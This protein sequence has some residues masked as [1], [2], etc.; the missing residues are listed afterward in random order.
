MTNIKKR[1]GTK[2]ISE[3]NG[4]TA[5]ELLITLF[6]A[7]MFLASGFQLYSVVMKSGGETRVQA[8]ASNIMYEYL[9]RYKN[10]TSDLCTAQTP[11]T[12]Q[13]V[14][15]TG[16]ASSTVTVVITCPYG[17]T[18]PIS[19]VAVSVKYGNPQQTVSEATFIKP[20]SIVND[21]L[22]MNLDAGSIKSFKG[23]RSVINWDSWTVGTGAVT[24]YALNGDG[25]SR[26]IDTNPWGNADVVWDTSNQDSAND[27]D[28]GWDGSSFSIDK[29]KMYRFSTWVRRK[30]IGIKGA[31]FLGT[32]G[33]GASVLNRSDGAANSNPYFSATEWWGGE[34]QWYLVVGYVWPAGSGTGAVM[35][36]SGIFMTNGVKVTSNADFVW[37]PTTT[38]SN[39][40]SY[41]YYSTDT[42]TNQQWYQPR[43][44]IV[45]GTEPTVTELINDAGN[46]WTDL[47]GNN[48][49]GILAGGATYNSSNGGSISFDGVNDTVYLGTGNTFFPIPNFS[50]ELWFKSNG[51]TPVTGTSPGLLGITY[52]V[53]IFVNSSSLVFSLDDGAAFSAVTTVGPYSFYDSSWHQVVIQANSTTRNIYVDGLLSNTANNS[54]TG[55]TRWPTNVA[56]M[57]RDNNNSMYYFNG[58]ISSAKFYNKVLSA[59]EVKQNFDALRGRYGI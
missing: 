27:A 2:T 24:G 40:R 45:D 30:T 19:K 15:V 1:L 26:V 37:Q 35:P 38:S 29:T 44:D 57:G 31:F 59:L 17:I 8:N 56:N 28:G 20:Q 52:G 48:R 6:I 25:N 7:A 11:V 42:T 43:V 12:D 41:L 9:Q 18:S 49:K 58:N 3:S 5:V 47:S 39:H 23:R 10:T 32:S 53:R 54:W 33:G 36:D 22:I 34:N 4:F 50:M 46:T 21:G 55:S 14:T 16:S 51:T 13:P